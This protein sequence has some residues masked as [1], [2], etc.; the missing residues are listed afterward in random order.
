MQIPDDLVGAVKKIFTELR[1]NQV[2]SIRTIDVI[3]LLKGRFESDVGVLAAFSWNASI[4]RLLAKHAAVLG[5]TS[6]GEIPVKDD[7][8]HPTHT[9]VWDLIYPLDRLSSMSIRANT[10]LN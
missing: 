5:I 4:G 2:R 3:R 1:E 8:G 7:N 10:S 6:A 9:H